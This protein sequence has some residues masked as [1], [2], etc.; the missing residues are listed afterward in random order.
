MKGGWPILEIYYLIKI[1][2]HHQKPLIQSLLL[3]SSA[4]CIGNDII[5]SIALYL[6][7]AADS[8]SIELDDVKVNIS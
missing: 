5:R 7:I 3:L 4:Q 6:V 1:R 2:C 8:I